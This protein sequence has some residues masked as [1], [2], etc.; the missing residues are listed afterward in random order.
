MHCS[1]FTSMTTTCQIQLFEGPQDVAGASM[2]EIKKNTLRLEK[3]YNFY[4]QGS[5]LCAHI[6]SRTSESISIDSETAAILRHA[7]DLCVESKGHFDITNGTIK[8]CY[9]KKTVSEMEQLFEE[10]RKWIGADTWELEGN[11]LC[12]SNPHTRF[13]LGGLIKEYAVDEAAAILWEHGCRS[14]IVN[15]GGDVRV[16]GQKPDGKPFGVAI[17][18]PINPHQVLA[19]V[20]LENQALTTSSFTERFHEIEGSRYPHILSPSRNRSPFL[21]ATVI[22]ATTLRCGAFSTAFML[23][24]DIPV[25]ADLKM[26]LIDSELRL[27]QNIMKQPCIAGTA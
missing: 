23:S 22:G 3:K 11:S 1:T 19:V 13:D 8:H 15:F 9:M 2:A 5:Y 14:A 26:I 17:K 16:L 7:R 27:H 6:N 21:S 12:F 24:A 10:K 4:D 25:P 20:N 18:D